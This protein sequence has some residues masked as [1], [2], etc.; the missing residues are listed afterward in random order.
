MT[1]LIAIHG[2]Q[3]I[4]NDLFNVLFVPVYFILFSPT[5]NSYVN[6]SY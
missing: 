1:N 3:K 6:N 4:L 2:K 5:L